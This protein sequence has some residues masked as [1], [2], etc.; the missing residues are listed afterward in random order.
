MSEEPVG[1]DAEIFYQKPDD[2]IAIVTLNRPDKRNAVNAALAEALDPVVRQ[3]ER[4]PDL[5]VVVLGS[6]NDKS[7]CAGAEVA[8]GGFG[9]SQRRK[10]WIAAI[11][12]A[13]LAGDCQLAL[14]CDL[15][16]A[17]QDTKFG[18][19]EVKRGL[20]AAAVGAHWLVRALPSNLAI[21]LVI[22]GDS[23]D[24]LRA[25]LL[26]LVNRHTCA[27]ISSTRRRC[28]WP[29]RSPRTPR[30]RCSKASTSHGWAPNSSTRSCAHSQTR[31]YSA[32]WPPRMRRRCSGPS[33][34]SVRRSGWATSNLAPES[35]A[36]ANVPCTALA[37][38][39]RLL[40]TSPRFRRAV[41]E[42]LTACADSRCVCALH[43]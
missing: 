17:A 36:L 29:V 2:H 27:P 42:P 9:H 3:S 18:I 37:C 7:F 20:V 1:L 11:K 38:D 31:R 28:R 34:R 24:A 33:W 4:A 8:Q 30:A 21:E 5:R 35:A 6:S 13:T 16:V 25:Y 41:Q 32:S 10:P 40:G 14:A 19:P 15:V 43:R 22:T 26:G 39:A 23:L 12:G